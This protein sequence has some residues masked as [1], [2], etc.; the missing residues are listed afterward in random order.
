MANYNLLKLHQGT[1]PDQPPHLELLVAA[2]QGVE[3]AL[4][5]NIEKA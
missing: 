2:I 1:H 3:S 4:K 5:T